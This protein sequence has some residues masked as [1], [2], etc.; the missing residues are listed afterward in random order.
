MTKAKFFS[1]AIAMAL[2]LSMGLATLAPGEVLAQPSDYWA[3]TYGGEEGDQANSIQQTSDG[4]YIMAGRTWSFGAGIHDYWVLKLDANGDVTWQ[5]TYGGEDWDQANSIQQTSDGGYIVAGCTRSFGA[6][7]YDYWVLKL[8]ANGGVTWQKTYGGENEDRAY[9]IQQTSDGGYIVAGYKL[10]GAFSTDYW[11]LKLDANGSIP[12]CPLGVASDA[13]IEDTGVAG[14]NT[15]ILGEGTVADIES[16]EYETSDTDC[17]IDTQCYYSPPAPS[18]AGVP[19]MNQ[20]GIVAMIALLAGLLVWAV[21][22]RRLA[23]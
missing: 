20:W 22:R 1:I 8:D 16:P 5:K 9:S 19:A 15:D 4:G 13:Q 23:S 18:P 6:G 14:E 21:R 17:I 3:K 7:H 10:S 12:E 11:V 2:V